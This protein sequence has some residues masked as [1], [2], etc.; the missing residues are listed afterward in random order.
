MP[1]QVVTID[2][3]S[4]LGVESRCAL[5]SEMLGAEPQRHDLAY[6]LARE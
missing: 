5:L 6:A 1:D 2:H 3:V 4:R